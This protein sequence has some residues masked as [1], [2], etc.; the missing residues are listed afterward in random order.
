EQ[1][2]AFEAALVDVASA[3][4]PEDVAT[5]ARQWRDA[6]D[7]DRQDMNTVAAQQYEA[8][9]LQLDELLDGF[10]H[11]D[12]CADPDAA[13]RIRPAVDIAYEKGHREND[14]RS[15]GQQRLDALVTVCDHYTNCET[16]RGS[17][18]QLMMI[19]DAPTIR[20]EAIGLCET[21]RGLRV[22]PETM[23][24]FACDA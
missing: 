18:R 8:R 20:G 11:I 14:P 1:F 5:I 6:L 4:L 12:G 21:D 16:P 15:Q 24:R 2:A 19:T 10:T 22:S 3:G 23:R 9:Y 13:A 7:A 17:G